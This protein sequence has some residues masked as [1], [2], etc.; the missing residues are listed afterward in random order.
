[1][2]R[3]VHVKISTYRLVEGAHL[4]FAARTGRLNVI[5]FWG[6]VPNPTKCSC[7]SLLGYGL[8]AWVASVRAWAASRAAATRTDVDVS[9]LRNG[10]RNVVPGLG[11]NVELFDEVGKDGV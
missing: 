7:T 10:L 1:M 2:H 5:S 6:S 4:F 8:G 3:S 9:G 11:G